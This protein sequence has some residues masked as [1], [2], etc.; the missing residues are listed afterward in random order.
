ME[1][2]FIKIHPT[3]HLPSKCVPHLSDTNRWDKEPSTGVDTKPPVLRFAS[4][5]SRL[6][7]E[8]SF[9]AWTAEDEE[10]FLNVVVLGLGDGGCL[11]VIE[12][13]PTEEKHGLLSMPSNFQ[14][15]HSCSSFVL[16]LSQLWFECGDVDASQPFSGSKSTKNMSAGLKTLAEFWQIFGD[17]SSISDCKKV[18]K[19]YFKI[20][21]YSKGI[22]PRRCGI[23]IFILN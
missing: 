11:V 5:S 8:G 12:D 9:A 14:F 15:Q 23:K 13:E 2:H 19:T 4:F 18:Q 6:G 20:I 16:S 21:V 1:Q 10:T 22:S 7:L 17:F 3:A